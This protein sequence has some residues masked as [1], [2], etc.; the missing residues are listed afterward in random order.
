MSTPTDPRQEL[1]DLAAMRENYAM[2]GLDVT[3]VDPDPL[4]QFGR[5][6]AEA[7]A[8]PGLPEPTAMVL[9]TVGELGQPSARMVLLKGVRDWVDGGGGFDFFTNTESHKGTDLAE[10]ARCSL[11]FPWHGLERQVRIEGVAEPL[12]RAVVEAYFAARPRGSQLGA[13][14]SQQSRPVPDRAALD[15]AWAAADATFP[16]EVPVPPYWSGYCVRPRSFEFWQGRPGRM[17]DRITYT[18]APG[19]GWR[20]GRLAP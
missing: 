5:W 13:W 9:A 20:V 4:V 16:D 18:P 7:L 1:P 19:G 10:N 6:L 2:A 8:V 12:P 3:E 11:L 15:E 14:A 17:H